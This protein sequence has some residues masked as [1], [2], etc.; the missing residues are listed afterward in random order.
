MLIRI[1]TSTIS[2]VY[3]VATLPKNVPRRIFWEVGDGGRGV[4]LR[5]PSRVPLKT[6]WAWVF[7]GTVYLKHTTALTNQNDSQ[8]KGLQIGLVNSLENQINFYF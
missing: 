2:L 6:F 7:K 4:K 3:R 5:D 1:L 8:V